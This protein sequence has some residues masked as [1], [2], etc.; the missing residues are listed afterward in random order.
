MLDLLLSNDGLADAADAGGAGHGRNIHRDLEG[1]R[2]IRVYLGRYVNVYAHVEILKLG[3][4]QRVNADAANAGLERPGCHR[5]ALT[6]FQRGFLAIDCP[7]LRLL[8]QLGG[9]VREQCGCSHRADRG[10][11]V[12]RGQVAEGVQV[13]LIR[14]SRGR[15][16]HTGRWGAACAGG[17]T[18]VDVVLQCNRGAG[19]RV[20]PIG[21]GFVLVDLKDGNVNDDLSFGLVEVR[22]Q[23]LRQRH[24]IRGATHDDR[25]LR[26]QGLDAG[27]FQNLAQS[28]DHILQFGGLRQIGHVER[29]NNALFQV[30]ALCG[31]VGRHENRVGRYRPPESLRFEGDNLQ[32]L[33]QS[34]SIQLNLDATRG[35]I[36]IEQN[37]D[38]RQFPHCFVNHF[39]VFSKLE[40][41]GNVRDRGQVHGSGGL[42]Q[43]LLQSAFGGSGRLFSGVLGSVDH[44]P[45]ALK[46]LLG[47]RACSINLRRVLELGQRFLQLP[48]GAQ[49]LSAMHMRGSGKE[50]Q[51]FKGRAIG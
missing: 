16:A 32:S 43:A 40:G 49:K 44:F 33:L 42:V 9:A 35:V 5:N 31:V 1:Y 2:A 22:D 11:E 36:R 15:V 4:D 18:C 27:N 37:V 14:G 38:S 25:G 41:D 19:G 13:D 34:H 39:A 26:G 51:P 45:G 29:L 17:G 24:L 10:R 50:T 46:F 7:N 23:L 48:G 3:I 20:D 30:F 21:L 12:G 47:N 28:V 6:D 8:D